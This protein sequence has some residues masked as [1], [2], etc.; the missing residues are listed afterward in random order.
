[1]VCRNQDNFLF[2]ISEKNQNGM[3]EY[4]QFGKD[5][6]YYQKFCREILEIA[7]IFW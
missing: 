7:S 1:M 6:V 5:F 2:L 3:E 4:Q